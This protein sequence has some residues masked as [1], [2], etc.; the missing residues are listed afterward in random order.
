[1]GG[2]GAAWL[3]GEAIVIWRQVHSSH[4]LPVPAQLIGVTGLFV[5]LALVAD[6]APAARPVVTMLGWGLDLAGLLN[7]LP[8]GL[9]GQISTAEAAQTGQ[10]GGS[11]AQEGIAGPAKTPAARAV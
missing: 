1:M 11:G 3:L 4:K 2:L 9:M 10:T 6:S 5:V 8:A 7:V